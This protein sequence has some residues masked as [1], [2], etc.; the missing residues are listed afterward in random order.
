ML[1]GDADKVAQ[2]FINGGPATGHSH[3]IKAFNAAYDSTDSATNS[4]SGILDGNRPENEFYGEKPLNNAIS[5]NT[6]NSPLYMVSEAGSC[7]HPVVSGVETPIVGMINPALS[8]PANEV[9]ATNPLVGS[10]IHP[11]RHGLPP[12]HIL[13]RFPGQILSNLF[14]HRR[15]VHHHPVY[16]GDFIRSSNV[17]SV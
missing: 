7:V 12:H 6:Y 3:F 1:V 2:Y 14:G 17:S 16:H 11:Y 4:F 8:Y 5:W 13:P 9:Y 10:I 15:A